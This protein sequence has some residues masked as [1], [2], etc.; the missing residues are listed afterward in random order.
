MA[1]YKQYIN[2]SNFYLGDKNVDKVEEGHCTRFERKD[3]EAPTF[4]MISGEWTELT[5]EDMDNLNKDL[6]DMIEQTN[7]KPIQ[8]TIQREKLEDYLGST[9]VEAWEVL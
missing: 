1:N 3:V 6:F 4:N 9:S 8:R 5:K 7:P 2:A